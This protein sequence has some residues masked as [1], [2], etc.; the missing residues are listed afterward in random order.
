MKY[1]LKFILSVFLINCLVSQSHQSLRTV[2]SWKQLDFNFPNDQ[3]RQTAIK[4][5]Q[6]NASNAVPIDVDVHYRGL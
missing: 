2:S 5:G 6:F 1:L 3:V 4:S